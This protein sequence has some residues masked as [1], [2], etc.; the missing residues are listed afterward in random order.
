[1]RSPTDPT[2]MKIMLASAMYHGCDTQ[3]VLVFCNL[4]VSG[5][6]SSLCHHI[7]SLQIKRVGL[8]KCNYFP[9][10]KLFTQRS[11]LKIYHYITNLAMT[12]IFCKSRMKPSLDPKNNHNEEKLA[13]VLCPVSIICDIQ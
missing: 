8:L 11:V 2:V 9:H 13:I 7:K 6:N 3:K 5:C 12:S 4:D 1:M 10:Y